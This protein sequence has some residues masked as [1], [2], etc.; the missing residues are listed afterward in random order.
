MKKVLEILKNVWKTVKNFFIKLWRTISSK[1]GFLKKFI[2]EEKVEYFDS[3]ATVQRESKAH[4]K[5]NRKTLGLVIMLVGS[6]VILVISVITCIVNCA[7]SYNLAEQYIIEEV[8]S[9]INAY[10]AVVKQKTD[11]IRLQVEKVALSDDIYTGNLQMNTRKNLLEKQTEGTDFKDFSIA[12]QDGTTYSNTD[13][14]Q[15][16][17]FKEAMNGTTYISSPLVRQTDGSITIMCGAKISTL[18]FTGVA[19]GGIDYTIFSQMIDSMKIGENSTS[20]ILDKNGTIIAHPNDGY[21]RDMKTFAQLTEEE[22]SSFSG[23]AAL[24]E[25]MIAGETGVEK[26]NYLGQDCYIGYIPVGNVENWSLALIIPSAAAFNALNSSIIINI[27]VVVL[28]LVLGAVVFMIVSNI[29]AK[30]INLITERLGLLAEGDLY[31]PV[32]VVKSTISETKMLYESLNGVT[33]SLSSITTDI[34]RVLGGLAEKNLLVRPETE[35]HGDYRSIRNSLITISNSL[36]LIVR[37]LE[38]V[39]TD[40]SNGSEQI[41]SSSQNLADS[42]IQQSSSLDALYENITQISERIEANVGITTKANNLVTDTVQR[43]NASTEKMAQMVA[44]MGEITKTSEQ[45][46]IIIQTIDEIAFQTN[47]LALNAAVEA[48][49]AGEAGKGFAVVADEVGN[50]AG[51]SAEAASNTAKLIEESIAAVHK[52]EEIADET[53]VA[54]NE[55][56]RNIDQINEFMTLIADASNE[57]A[58]RIT[59]INES[60]AVISALTQSTS[61]TSEECA[62]AS[63]EFSS[64]STVLKSIVDDFKTN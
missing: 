23:A 50:L 31:S 22:G 43:A 29:I 49:K 55:I 6:A 53:A 64:H 63:H 39:S 9:G 7:L 21:V 58:Q 60:M 62:A 15:R 10:Q 2:P 1:V 33:E 13:I 26:V 14:S 35:Y 52:G 30:P 5:Q 16:D 57:Q 54:L 51:K 37:S 12:Y 46:D 8:Q 25:K 19:Y 27:L 11:S 38:K 24:A 36:N 42:T 17:Y 4:A 40:V 44:S 41:L 47:I 56:V 59:G 45:I 18:T 3:E 48:A 61:A 20:F 34:D 28:L 32:P